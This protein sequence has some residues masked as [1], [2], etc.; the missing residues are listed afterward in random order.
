MALQVKLFQ[1]TGAKEIEDVPANINQWLSKE[2]VDDAAVKD[3]NTALCQV[4][5]S[6]GEAVQHLVITIWYTKD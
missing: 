6:R 4:G 5:A 1:A 3:T 2:I